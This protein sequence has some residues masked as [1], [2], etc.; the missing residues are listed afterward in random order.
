MS[1]WPHILGLGG[2]ALLFK[3]SSWHAEFRSCWTQASV[4]GNVTNIVNFARNAA[5]SAPV[6]NAIAAVKKAIG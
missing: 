6:D 5:L 4:T 2:Q 3:H 1:V